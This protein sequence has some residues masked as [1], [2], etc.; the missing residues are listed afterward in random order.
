MSAQIDTTTIANISLFIPHVFP[1]FTKEYIAY[2]FDKLQIGYVSGIDFVSKVDRHGRPYNA[3]YVHFEYWF[4]GAI[5]AN[6]QQLVLNPNKEARIVHDDP[7][8][9]IVL[10]NTAKKQDRDQPT[11]EQSNEALTEE[12][13]RLTSQIYELKKVT[14]ILE[15][16]RILRSNLEKELRKSQHECKLFFGNL[17]ALRK[18]CYE[19][20]SPQTHDLMQAKDMICQHLFERSFEEIDEDPNKKPPVQLVKIAPGL[21]EV[22]FSKEMKDEIDGLINKVYNDPMDLSC[23]VDE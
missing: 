18:I 20:L 5:A 15:A 7:W 1:N 19:I 2:V 3:A 10:E 6:F 11:K 22:V 23:E 21:S 4:D 9:W 12:N 8:Y 13:G 16:E 17:T 14:K